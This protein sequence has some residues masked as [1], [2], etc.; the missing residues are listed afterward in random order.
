MEGT[1]ANIEGVI[2]CACEQ[3]RGDV[4][5]TKKGVKIPPHS[6]YLS[7]YGGDPQAI[8]MAIHMKLGG[9]CGFAGNTSV[10]VQDTT[11]KT[12]HTYYYEVPE[13]T[14]FGVKVTLVKTPQ[15]AVTF[16]DDVKAALM[17]NFDGQ[18]S[19]YGRVKMGQ[20]VYA[21]RFYKTVL[22]AGIENLTSIEI[23]FPASDQYGDKVEIPLDK[24]P[25]LSASDIVIVATAEEATGL[26]AKRKAARKK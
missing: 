17:Q 20:T 10:T 14:P 7:V 8:G 4:E 3:N 16:E 13:A 23:S 11:S 25:T 12:N 24:L 2:A 15:T 9:G 5:I 26:I 21:S 19:E 22:N 1:V 6:I 18:L